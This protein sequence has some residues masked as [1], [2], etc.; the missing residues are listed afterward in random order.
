MKKSLLLFLIIFLT[1]NFYGRAASPGN[2]DADLIELSTCTTNTLVPFKAKGDYFSVWDGK[3][4]TELFL[5]GMNLGVAVPG[6]FPGELAATAS[7][8]ARWFAQIKAI[9]YNNIRVYTLHYPR[10]YE[11]LAKYNLAHPQSPLLLFQGIW[12]EEQDGEIDLYG[13]EGAFE[14]EIEEVIDC[15]HGNRTIPARFGKAYGTYAADVS[16]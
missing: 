4:Y 10:F 2:E 16:Q 3:G 7:Q 6:T 1:A 11:E 13:Q 15:V 14:T 5:K 9:G 8:Y 12:L